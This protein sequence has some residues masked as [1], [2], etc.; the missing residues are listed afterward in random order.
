MLFIYLTDFCNNTSFWSVGVLVLTPVKSF[1]L[2]TPMTACLTHDPRLPVLPLD[3]SSTTPHIT[4]FT[5]NFP[6][7]SFS[8]F[9]A[10]SL[11]IGK[12]LRSLI[13]LVKASP[14]NDHLSAPGATLHA[15]N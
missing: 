4:E 15:R 10:T 3:S 6:V 9:S 1:H 12:D 8:F 7:P 2:R 11:L 13:K 5:T 14:I